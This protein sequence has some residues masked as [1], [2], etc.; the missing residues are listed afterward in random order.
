MER[1]QDDLFEN[2]TMT[3]GEHLEELRQSLV[4]AAI[5]LAA[6]MVL[7]LLVADRVVLFVQTP[8]Q[9]AIQKFN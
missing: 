3:F 5:A 6:G 7:G 1:P 4:R 9:T 8:L 2:S